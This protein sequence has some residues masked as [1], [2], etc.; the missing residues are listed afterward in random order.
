MRLKGNIFILSFFKSL[1]LSKR[2]KF[3]SVNNESARKKI[4][5][6]AWDLKGKYCYCARPDQPALDQPPTW[7]GESFSKL[8]AQSSWLAVSL[9]TCLPCL[10]C[11]PIYISFKI[12]QFLNKSENFRRYR[13]KDLHFFKIHTFLMGLV[14]N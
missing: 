14:T 4:E 2:L 5:V 3:L 12:T 6:L 9:S 7:R 11:L 10:P 1:F 13:I 8:L